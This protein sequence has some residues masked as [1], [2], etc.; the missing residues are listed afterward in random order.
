MCK[1]QIPDSKYNPISFKY[2][3]FLLVLFL[4]VNFSG[5][6]DDYEYLDRSESVKIYYPEIAE[7]VTERNLSGLMG[8]ISH[9]DENVSN[10]AWRAI[11]HTDL[12]SEEKDDLYRVVL[13]TDEEGGWFALSFHELSNSQLQTIRTE[14]N[15]GQILSNSVC[16]VFF[17]Q[18]DLVDLEFIL[19]NEDLNQIS[20]CSKAIGGILSRREVP[21]RLNRDVINLAF[22]SDD[23]EIRRNLLYGYFRS[24]ANRPE[25]ESGFYLDAMQNW[26]NF[27]IGN[28]EFV[29][30]TMVRLFGSEAFQMVMDELTDRELKKLIGLSVDLASALNRMTPNS[31]NMEMIFRLLNHDNPHVTVQALASLTQLDRISNEIL[32]RIKSEI[33]APTREAEVFAA[34]LNLFLKNDIDI[35]VH[36]TRLDYFAERNPFLTDR[37]LVIYSALDSDEEYFSRLKS[38]IEKGEIEA[39]HAG[40]MM[41]AF[42]QRDGILSEFSEQADEF[43]RSELSRGNRSALDGLT[44]LLL[45]DEIIGEDDITLLNDTYSKY[46]EDGLIESAQIIGRILEERIPDQ[47]SPSR[48]IEDKNFHS[49]DFQKLYEMG[50]RPFWTLKTEK[51]TVQVKLDP[52]TAPFTVSSIYSLTRNGSYNGVAFH[53]VVRNFVAQGGD[54]DRHDGFGGPEYRIPTEPS[55]ETFERGMA[56][57]ASSGIDTEGSQFFFMHRWAPHLDGLYTNFGQIT[58]GLDVLDK[59]QVGDKIIEA[60][61][62]PKLK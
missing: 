24:S 35:S 11:A 7:H 25:G 27:G 21:E 19:S 42:L 61:I 8:F 52:I 31:S 3:S 50:V 13:D 32:S 17:R 58:R 4:M 22:Q 59:L 15:T 34:A 39:L 51:G 55:F 47:F 30:M 60:S 36:R 23:S 46:V 12:N 2:S 5:C 26:Q 16:E 14:L 49:P 37:F 10:L 56:G 1:K 20:S 28:Y 54:F 44:E 43:I 38:L 33:V 48:E 18:G 45:N 6:T 57:I 62:Y 41:T 40:R 9:E 53:R 29:D